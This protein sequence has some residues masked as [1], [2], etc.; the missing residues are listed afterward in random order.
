MTVTR[1]DFDFFKSVD[2]LIVQSLNAEMRRDD[3]ATFDIAHAA[4]SSLL[5]GID[6]REAMFN[7]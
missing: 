7:K 2:F 6:H 1:F 5:D 3:D 4:A